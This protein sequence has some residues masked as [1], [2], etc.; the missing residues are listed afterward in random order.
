VATADGRVQTGVIARQDGGTV[1]L[2]T[3]DRTE[4]KLRPEEVEALSPSPTS[5]MPQGLDSVLSID[6]LRDLLSF[7]RQLNANPGR[8]TRR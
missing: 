4:V 3:A 5:I 6:E 2:R 8:S 7:L 1:V